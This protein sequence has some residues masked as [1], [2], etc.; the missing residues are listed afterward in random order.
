MWIWSS[1]QQWYLRTFNLDFKSPTW[2]LEWRVFLSSKSHLVT[3]SQ[4]NKMLKRS[5]F[6]I[7]NFSAKK[8]AQKLP[9][10]VAQGDAWGYQLHVL[11]CS[12]GAT[13]NQRCPTQAGW[14]QRGRGAGR[15]VPA[16]SGPQHL[17]LAGPR[18][19]VKPCDLSPEPVLQASSVLFLIFYT[20][21]SKSKEQCWNRPGLGLFKKYTKDNF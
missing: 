8:T 19:E 5:F 11:H 10:K 18:Q 2:E 21:S 17:A 14:M 7:W 15:G 13:R 3:R 9:Y 6:V 16:G 20:L 12:P 4:N 1:N